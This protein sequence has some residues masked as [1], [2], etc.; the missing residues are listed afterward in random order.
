MM[1]GKR[2]DS[3]VFPIEF[4]VKLPTGINNPREFPNITEVGLRSWFGQYSRKGFLKYNDR[5]RIVEFYKEFE[6]Y[7]SDFNNDEKKIVE[8]QEIFKINSNKVPIIKAKKH[9]EIGLNIKN[10]VKLYLDK[11]DLEIKVIVS[12]K[13]Y[14]GINVGNIDRKSFETRVPQNR[15]FFSPVSLHPKIARALVNLA[16][17]SA[18]DIL[19]DP[20]CGTGGIMIEAGL[21]GMEIVGCDIDE[22]MVNGCKNNYCRR[23]YPRS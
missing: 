21:I 11:P 13:I 19:L 1:K 10:I 17:L 9:I 12:E 4:P 3:Y 23:K 6:P 18:G 8:I 16:H 20:F 2:K 5:T 15:P 7:D 14:F 22:N